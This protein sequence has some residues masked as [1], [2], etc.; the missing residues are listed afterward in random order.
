MVTSSVMC[1]V[2]EPP[3]DEV[4]IKCSDLSNEEKVELET[5]LEAQSAVRLVRRRM[6][7]VDQAIDR[8]TL[9]LITAIPWDIVVVVR[10]SVKEALP[11]VVPLVTLYLAARKN[12]RQEEKDRKQQDDEST[13]LVQIAD[14]NGHTVAIV[15][16]HKGKPAS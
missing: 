1:D 4:L 13:E 9:G 15:K 7:T 14:A 16:R 6:Y 5:F 3:K 2:I 10:D 8:N 12:R 11:Y